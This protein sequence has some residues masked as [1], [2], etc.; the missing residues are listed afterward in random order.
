MLC[1]TVGLV[2]LKCL[3]RFLSFLNLS[4]LLVS[5][6]VA[7]LVCLLRLLQLLL[8]AVTLQ[9]VDWDNAPTYDPFQLILTA[10]QLDSLSMIDLISSMLVSQYFKNHWQFN[11]LSGS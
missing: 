6:E 8:F 10:T 7:F 2:L 5:L 1:S 11:I 3:I 4:L 9:T